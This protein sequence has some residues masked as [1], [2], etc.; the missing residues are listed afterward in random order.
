MSDVQVSCASRLVQCTG[1]NIFLFLLLKTYLK[2]SNMSSREET[3][4]YFV[5]FIVQVDNC[6]IAILLK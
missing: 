1:R 5:L 6:T 4:N 2:L 3:E